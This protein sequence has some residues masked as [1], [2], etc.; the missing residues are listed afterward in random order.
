M[1]LR[2]SF[3]FYPADWRNNAKLGR[4]SRAA[5]SAWL[6]IMCVLHDSDEYGVVRWPLVD[7]ARAAHVPMSLANELVDK[8]VLKGGDKSPEPYVFRP[9]HAG[10]HGD[11]VVLVDTSGGG[12]TWFCS[13]LVRDEWVRLRRGKNT[14]FNNENS[15]PDSTPMVGIGV[16]IG[17]ES[18]DGS[19]SSSS[20]SSSEVE[21]ERNQAV[22]APSAKALIAPKRGAS[23]HGD[24]PGTFEYERA[25]EY[26]RE[27]GRPDLAIRVLEIAEGFRDHHRAKGTTSKDWAASWRTWCRNALKFERAGNGYGRQASAHDNAFTGALLAIRNIEARA[28]EAEHAGGDAGEAQRQLPP[29]EREP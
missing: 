2:P 4:C 29:P 7:L 27:K 3:Q 21:E 23:L 26:W 10:K 15:S 1:A 28:A 11:G 18:G 14:R 12:P 19:S 22:V 24:F 9:Y 5:R 17:D 8:Q 25:Q 16:V 6:D 13:R 20:S